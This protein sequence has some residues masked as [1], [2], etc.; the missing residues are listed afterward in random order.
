MIR[1]G[2]GRAP[3][4]LAV[5]LVQLGACSYVARDTASYERDTS[6]LLD[7]RA[8][9]VQACYASE[10]A[11]NPNL[12]VGTLTITFRVNKKTGKL[13]PADWDRN[14]TTVSETLATCVVTAL[15]GLELDQPDRRDGEATYSYGFRG[16]P[17]A[18]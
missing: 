1:L 15:A 16:V 6:A 2:R 11:R 7:T 10:L 4:L 17:S 12:T 8:D 5:C 3:L 18:P 13:S 9:A 14:R